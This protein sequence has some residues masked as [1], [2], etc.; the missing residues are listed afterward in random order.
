MHSHTR[1]YNIVVCSCS[2]FG[3]AIERSQLLLFTVAIAVTVA[4]AIV[5]TTTTAQTVVV[6][7]S[8]LLRS[9]QSA[10]TLRLTYIYRVNKNMNRTDFQREPHTHTHGVCVAGL[11]K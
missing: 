1:T 9:D 8:Q 6:V 5:A 10:H 11:T 7:Q 4:T 2:T 3:W